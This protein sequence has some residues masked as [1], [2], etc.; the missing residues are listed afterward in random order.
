MKNFNF[1]IDEEREEFELWVDGECI[2][3]C[4]VFCA[5]SDATQLMEQLV[6]FADVPCFKKL[7]AEEVRKKMLN[8]E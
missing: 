3:D 4:F 6:E 2:T 8:I 1:V 5:M 7:S